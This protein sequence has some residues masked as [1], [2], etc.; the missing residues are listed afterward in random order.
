MDY[1][2]AKNQIGTYAT[3]TATASNTL[4]AKNID[5]VSLEA[6]LVSCDAL[7]IQGTSF[8][9][10]V[11]TNTQN[12]TAIPNETTFAGNV[13]T[14]D[15]TTNRVTAID[16]TLGLSVLSKLEQSYNTT[17]GGVNLYLTNSSLATTSSS[18]TGYM[19]LSMGTSKTA[20]NNA[21]QMLYFN[22]LSGSTTNRLDFRMLGQT[23]A[24]LSM[25]HG[26]ATVNGAMTVTGATSLTGTLAATGQVVATIGQQ[27]GTIAWS[28]TAG[29]NSYKTENILA[30][31]QALN[32]AYIPRVYTLYFTQL[33]SSGYAAT[34][35]K[36]FIRVGYGGA[37]TTW[38][39]NYTGFV[40]ANS[41]NSLVKEEVTTTGIPVYPINAG[42]MWGDTYSHS[43]V[44]T[45][46]YMFAAGGGYIYRWEYTNVTSQVG[47]ATTAVATVAGTGYIFNTT[48][49]GRPTALGIFYGATNTTS[50]LLTAQI[51]SAHIQ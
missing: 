44:F 36:P 5:C 24:T 40:S 12:M 50:N 49:T 18:S 42:T 15:V 45:L 32:S 31:A 29:V 51:V 10:S 3:S 2:A 7:T 47:G 46:T 20:T 25:T 13:I 35:D 37:T 30:T 48:A 39:S 16:P 22:V 23:T 28:S 21:W 34:T 1:C 27:L 8:N 41:G 11:F 17:A 6:N 26:N 43:G 9:A 4:F 19:G 14:P 38:S 33:K